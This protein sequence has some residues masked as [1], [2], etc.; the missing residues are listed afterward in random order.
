MFRAIIN[1]MIQYT[2]S[3]VHRQKAHKQRVQSQ[4]YAV[5]SCD[6]DELI[7]LNNLLVKEIGKRQARASK[8]R[9]DRH[10]QL[11]GNRF[12]HMQTG[13]NQL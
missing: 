2:D 1:Y 13:Q 9:G 3:L 5:I 11:R 12:I 10:K 8:A 4:N 6:N 7:Y